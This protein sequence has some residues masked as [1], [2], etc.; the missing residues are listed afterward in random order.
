MKYLQRLQDNFKT[1]YPEYVKRQRKHMQDALDG[2]QDDADAMG[3]PIEVN[4]SFVNAL[5]RMTAVVS[6]ICVI[7]LNLS[8]PWSAAQAEVI[9]FVMLVSGVFT[10]A[11]YILE[12]F[13][14][15]MESDREP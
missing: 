11:L 14:I 2:M 4:A 3:F 5:L 12:K 1:L 10:V 6:L 8:L 15:Y 9:W 7:L 13:A